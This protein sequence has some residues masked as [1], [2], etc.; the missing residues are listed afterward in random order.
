MDKVRVWTDLK[1]DTIE[2][3]L[4]RIYKQSEKEMKEKWNAYIKR[5]EKRISAAEKDYRDAL[6]VGDEQII[7]EKKQRLKD[8]KEEFTL[9]NANYKK[10]VD[11]VTLDMAKTNEKALKY[12]YGELPE[13]YA[14][15]Y[16]Q[17]NDIIKNLDVDFS[18]PNKDAIKRMVLDGKIKT[19]YMRTKNFLDIPKDQRWNTRF[20]NNEV[21]QGI[22]QGESMD[23]ISQRIFPEIMKKTTYAGLTQ[24]GIEDRN[25]AAAIRNARTLVTGAENRGK[26]DSYKELDKRGIVQKKVWIATGDN[27]TRDWHLS[28]DGQEVDLD[29]NFVDGNENELRYP[30]DPDA[31]PETVYNCRCAMITRVV[32][33]RNSDGSIR[34]IERIDEGQDL[35]DEQIEKEKE[36][37]EKKK[38]NGI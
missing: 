29:E 23:R 27:R 12:V 19:P 13:I 22:I 18:L 28:M 2:R 4:A 26:L 30:A 14:T 37:R 8:I 32:G 33:F 31:E 9:R 15:N 6:K 17:V 34:E 21:L 3:R 10:M 20:I 7:A 5:G 11:D 1:L 24:K 38:K 16:A 25:K 35:H 36:K